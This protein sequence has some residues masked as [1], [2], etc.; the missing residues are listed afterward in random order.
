[1]TSF[2]LLCAIL[3]LAVFF[4]AI[5]A[6]AFIA[7]AAAWLIWRFAN[8]VQILHWPGLLFSIRVFP[9]TL[10]AALTVGLALPSFLLLEPRRSVEAP[11]PYLILLA[12]LA[13]TI[14]ILLSLRCAK[15]L[16]HSRKTVKKW[17]HAS[18]LL[19]L[20]SSVPVYQLQS[21]DSIIAVA[22]ILRPKIFVGKAALA[23]LTAQELR[24]AIAHEVAH[25]HSLDNFKQLA[26]K[27]TKLQYFFVSLAKL[28][29]VWSAATELGAD[30]R[31]LHD[32]NSALELC[33]AIV[34]VG[35]LK[36]P[37]SDGLS[38][39][40]CHLVPPDR[41]ASALAIRVQHLFQAL[42]VHVKPRRQRKYGWG[43]I[44]L[45]TTTIYV[46][47]LPTLL[48]LVHRWMEYLA[49]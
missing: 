17:L 22:G 19:P 26:L 18:E 6:G 46:L 31:A 14:F 43:S 40:T 37:P 47:T 41:G 38:F 3:S 10:G 25:V 2:W 8:K 5:I 42:D 49:R 1:M 24:A 30:A 44:L 23:S 20:S 29:P 48:P 36:A 39:A 15:L 21:P 28:D 13:F 27:L 11:E 16:S 7:N 9:I 12:S 33:S 35:R 45:I 34:K 32:G 4:I